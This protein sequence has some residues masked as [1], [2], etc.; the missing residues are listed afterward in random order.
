MWSN[1]AKAAAA[2]CHNFSF[3]LTEHFK[4]WPAEFYV[5]C[6]QRS[7]ANS[8]K[9]KHFS[10]QETEWAIYHTKCSV[11]KFKRAQRRFGV[12]V[13]VRNI[14]FY[15]P[16]EYG[17][18]I[19][20]EIVNKNTFYFYLLEFSHPIKSLINRLSQAIAH[21]Y[22][23]HI[24]WPTHPPEMRIT[25]QHKFTRSFLGEIDVLWNLIKQTKAK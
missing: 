7:L 11:H 19:I 9:Q 6:T 22:N 8:L 25:L 4:C 2:Y 12:K 21:T 3:H 15:L 10:E 16:A 1:P 23:R 13:I 5:W 18:C 24:N 14:E 17:K 20:F